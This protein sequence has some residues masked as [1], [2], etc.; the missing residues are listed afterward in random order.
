MGYTRH[1]NNFVETPTEVSFDLVVRDEE[2]KYTYGGGRVTLPKP[3]TDAQLPAVIEDAV[4]AIVDRGNAAFPKVPPATRP[5]DDS[6]IANR[7]A[8]VA[9]ARNRSGGSII[10]SR[11]R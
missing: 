6:A 1:V 5:V 8:D 10:R 4:A 3:L 9:I 2:D 7:I 11:V